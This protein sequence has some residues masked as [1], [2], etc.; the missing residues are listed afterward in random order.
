MLNYTNTSTIYLSQ[1]T[2]N[3]NYTGYKPISDDLGNGPIKSIQR[4]EEMLNTMRACGVLQPITVKVMGDFYLTKPIQ[5]GYE[6]VPSVFGNHH[7][8]KNV[9]FES[10]GEQRARLIGGKK[11]T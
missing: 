8:M 1:E 3:D 9:T 2:G 5:L 7:P 4:L 11:L 6:L 10:Y